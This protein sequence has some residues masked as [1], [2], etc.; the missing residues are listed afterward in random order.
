MKK[1]LLI[2]QAG[3][4]IIMNFFLL[5][6][7]YEV[8]QPS[9]N[10]G[11]PGYNAPV[12]NHVEEYDP[13]L[14]RL[15][16]I[17]KLAVYCD[18]VYADRTYT[19]NNIE[20]E[21]EYPQVATEVIRKRFYHGYSLYGFG[22]NHVAMFASKASIGGLSAIVIPNDIL[23]YPYA[24]CSQQSIVLMKVLN[25]K[26][27][28]TRKV[29][30]MG[31]LGGHF[32]FEVFYNG[33]WH[34]VDPNMEPDLAVLNVYNRPGIAFLAARPDIL[35]QAYKQYP[36]EKIL[37]LFSNYS[38]GN[39][40][41]PAAPNAYLFQQVT[42]LLSYTIWTFFLVLFILVRKKYLSL[43][44]QTNVRNHRVH[45]PQLQPGPSQAFNVGY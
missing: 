29:G 45:F 35:L 43:S 39:V 16:N 33:A 27:F 10:L 3:L 4:F 28:K 8:F 36:K 18:S 41:A 12:Y 31:K 26:G 15:D 2:L 14:Q 37:D 11:R 7:V 25:Q 30:F 20:F 34:F 22:N 40:N 17:T 5:L 24:A 9:G 23:K 19:N 13:S 38:Y 1:L 6:A 32:C 44:R 21:T 42:K